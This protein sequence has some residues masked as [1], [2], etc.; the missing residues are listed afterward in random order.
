MGTYGNAYYGEQYYL[1]GSDPDTKHVKGMMDHFYTSS[2]PSNAAYWQ[3]GAIDKRFKVGDQT[4][5]SMIYGDNQYFQSRRFFF[6]LIRRHINMICGYQRKNRKSTVTMPVHENDDALAD[7]YNAV[8]KWCE[9]RDGFQEYLSQ[10]F[11]GSCDTGMSLLHLYPDYTLDPI[12]GDLFTDQVSYNNFL[13]DPYFR[14][15]D[16]TDCSF[17][18][19]RRWVNKNAAK[20]LLPGHAKE[21]DKMRPSGMKDG[22][23]PLQAELINL[24]TNQLFSYDEFHYRTTREATIVLD[25]K[26]GEAVEWDE[27][28]QDEEDTMERVLSQQPWLM[29]KKTQVPTVKLVLSLGGQPLYHGPNLLNIDPY[30][31]V[32]SLCYHEPD[33][34]SYAWR[35]QG[36]VRNLRDAQYLY[37]R[38]KVIE[39]DILESQINSGWIYPIDSV[40][41]PKAFRQSGQGFLIPLKAGHLASE[42]QRVEA[43]GIPQSMMELSRSLSEDITKISGVN[44]ELLGAATD[45]KSGI[46]SMLRQGAGLTTLQTIFDKLDY[47]QRLYGKIRLQAIRK[48]FSK[49]KIR[50]ILGHDAD[51]RFWTSHSQKYSVAVEEGNYTTSQRQMELQQLLHFKEIG[52]AISDK[53][54]LRAA[55]ITNKKQVI[56]DMEEQQKQQAQQAQA[57]AQQ[58]QQ[59]DQSKIMETMSKSQLNMAKVKESLAKVDDLEASADHKKSQADYEIVR[60]MVELEDMQLSQFRT[61]LELAETIKMANSGK[62]IGEAA[63]AQQ[64]SLKEAI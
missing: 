19:R 43:P 57:Q 1:D 47:T 52:M 5:W 50:N 36:V 28:E 12:S 2:Y 55:F 45:D 51:P 13:I 15:Q 40:V 39:L 41:D 32:P 56:A 38:R 4:L 34:Q 29:V 33:I 8:L 21:I 9:E 17:V 18:W 24:D 16:L 26:T 46:L 31:F 48:N 35:V 61:S 63:M 44:E 23:F 7:D 49:G 59:V 22:R 30:P 25:P 27:D 37:N 60:M 11:E 3:Q 42:I 10:S 14:K 64:N 58:Q 62:P 6:N 54:I 20:A 53:S